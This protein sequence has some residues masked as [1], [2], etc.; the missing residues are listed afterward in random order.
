MHTQETTECD[1]KK[2]EE[3]SYHCLQTEAT[4]EI[5][6][7]QTIL[8]NGQGDIKQTIEVINGTLGRIFE[9]YQQ[10]E[11]RL[12]E[13]DKL[14]REIRD[15]MVK[16]ETTNGHMEKDIDENKNDILTGHDNRLMI[17]NR[18]SKLESNYDHII[19]LLTESNTNK[20]DKKISRRT[21]QIAAFTC[22]A[23][24][25]LLLLILQ[26]VKTFIWKF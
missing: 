2:T 14:F 9:L 8:T 10:Q 22:I 15:F 17:E 18:I 23:G 26:M 24:P 4:N 12:N 7:T 19:S 11:K 3:E 20:S 5:Q 6:A 13:G 16:K 21:W 1:N 25:L